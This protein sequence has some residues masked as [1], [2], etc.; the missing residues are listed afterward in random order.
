MNSQIE[1]GM[2]ENG[3]QRI[4]SEID[5]EYFFNEGKKVFDFLTNVMIDRGL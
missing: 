1:D 2:H 4:L 5:S 3:F